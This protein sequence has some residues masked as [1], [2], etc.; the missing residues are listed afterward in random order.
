MGH[1]T[2]L[3][4]LL[5]DFDEISSWSS[6]IEFNPLDSSSLSFESESLNKNK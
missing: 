3:L 2:P 5:A 6:L 1:V 4:S